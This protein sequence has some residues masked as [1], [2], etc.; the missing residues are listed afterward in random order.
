MTAEANK[1][2]VLDAIGN[3][4]ARKNDSEANP[5]IFYSLIEAC[6]FAEEEKKDQDAIEVVEIIRLDRQ[7]SGM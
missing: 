4:L 5:Y 3:P 2:L 7:G 6:K 1:Y